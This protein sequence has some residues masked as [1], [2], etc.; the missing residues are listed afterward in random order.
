MRNP[1]L[2]WIRIQKPNG[3]SF[4]L[5]NTNK[6]WARHISKT[7]TDPETSLSGPDP[8]CEPQ[9]TG[10]QFADSILAAIDEEDIIAVESD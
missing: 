1:D 5:L 6:S 2:W 10:A 9:T 8:V 3:R 7:A 4:M